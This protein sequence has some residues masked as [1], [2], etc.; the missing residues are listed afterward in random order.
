MCHN[1]DFEGFD[2]QND[3]IGMG[4]LMFTFAVYR[5]AV[6]TSTDSAIFEGSKHTGLD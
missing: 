4:T 3:Q 2:P 6:I 1:Y 5:K